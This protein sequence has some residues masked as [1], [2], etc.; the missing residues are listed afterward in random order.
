LSPLPASPPLPLSLSSPPM[1]SSLPLSLLT[2]PPSSPLRRLSS[3]PMSP[4]PL[5]RLLTPPAAY[6]SPP[7]RISSTLTSSS[8]L[9]LRLSSRAAHSL[10]AGHV[11]GGGGAR[12]I[13]RGQVGHPRG[14]HL[15]RV[16]QTLLIQSAISYDLMGWKLYINSKKKCVWFDTCSSVFFF[17]SFG[18]ENVLGLSILHG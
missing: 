14:T 10:A 18:N 9:L 12:Q 2:P 11:A 6:S 15:A 16:L 7:L 13:L 17:C 8:P 1:L 4:S 5:L 3:P